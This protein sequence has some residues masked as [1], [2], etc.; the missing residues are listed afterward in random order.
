MPAT[1]VGTT[2]WHA[3]GMAKQPAILLGSE[4]HGI[5]SLWFDAAKNKKLAL[6]TVAL[7]ML[8]LADSLN[9]SATAAVLAY[10]SVRQR[11]A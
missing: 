4:A 1:P 2:N 11:N 9:V 3:A 6:Q 8:G 5:S 7:P 10:E